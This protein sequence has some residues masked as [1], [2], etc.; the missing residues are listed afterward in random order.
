MINQDLLDYVRQQSA[1]G[2]SRQAMTDSLVS[3]GWLKENIDEAF[4]REGGVVSGQPSLVAGSSS[5][6]EMKKRNFVLSFNILLAVVFTLNLVRVLGDF[7]Y[8]PIP[9]AMIG[10]IALIEIGLV[11]YW[12]KVLN[13]LWKVMGKRFG[14][15]IGLLFFI[16][17]FGIFITYGVGMV[18]AR[19]Y[20]DGNTF[21]KQMEIGFMN[22]KDS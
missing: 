7:G 2:V 19:A 11:I 9:G 17:N 22:K 18:V 5:Y 15:I 6:V 8:L 10:L 3:G 12:M 4:A 14:W 16:P 20:R 1:R 13:D 21:P